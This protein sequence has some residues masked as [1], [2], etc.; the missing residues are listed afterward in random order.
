M[1]LAA[2][3]AIAAAR[4]L[5]RLDAQLLLLHAIG[6]PQSGSQVERAEQL[7]HGRDVGAL[8]P[9]LDD[10][11]LAG[12]VGV[13]LQLFSALRQHQARDRFLAEARQ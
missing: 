5:E 12:T 2:A 13:E 7:V 4:G 11:K 8:G 3:L 10:A 9:R 6:R 1:T